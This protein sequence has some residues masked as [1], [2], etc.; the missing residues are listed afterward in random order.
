MYIFISLASI[1]KHIKRVK[2]KVSKAL[3]FKKC[4]VGDKIGIN[5]KLEKQQN[6]LK[7][8]KKYC[9]GSPLT[10]LVAMRNHTFILKGLTEQ[11][12]F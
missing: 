8:K 3:V 6:N 7:L 10:L 9:I 11:I 1:K 5:V 12:S 2:V 4:E